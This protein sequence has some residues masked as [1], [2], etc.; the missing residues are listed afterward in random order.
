M[1]TPLTV[2]DLILPG[3]PLEG[4]QSLAGEAGLDNPVTWVVSLRPFSPAFPRLRGGEIAL[5]ATEHLVR[6]DPPITLADVVKLLSSTRG[7]GIA[8][9]GGVSEAA[10]EAAR[11]AQ[12][13]L[14]LLPS[15]AP[16]ADLEQAIMRECAFHQART[17]IS[18]AEEPESW[19]EDLLSGRDDLQEGAISRAERQGYPPAR[20]YSVAFV[21]PRRASATDFG[22]QGEALGNLSDALREG[23][24]GPGEKPVAARYESGLAI[25]LPPG[26]ESGLC[27]AL[28]DLPDLACGIG[29]P[30]PLL[31]VTASLDEAFLA[32]SASALVKDGAPTHF[33]TLGPLLLLLLLQRDQSKELADFVNETIGSLSDHDVGTTNPLLPT[34]KAFIEHGGRLRDTAEHLYVHRNTLAY[35]LQKASEILGADLR[36]ADV[37]LGVQLAL[38]ALPLVRDIDSRR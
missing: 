2:R 24:A 7:A 34:V 8:V 19:L 10:V 17:E 14:L 37:R 15:D 6:H 20:Q 18:R 33:A 38:M 22:Q 30:R 32:A 13:A 21:V 11:L 27:R 23:T 25:L 31:Q 35:R 12:L 36:E 26:S 4:A 3:E 9:R 29:T 28:Q 1:T 5:V 16:L